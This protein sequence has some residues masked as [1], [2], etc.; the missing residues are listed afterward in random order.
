MRC[1]WQDA[2]DWDGGTHTVFCAREKCKRRFVRTATLAKDIRG[3]NSCR[4]FPIDPQ[5]A[6]PIPA[7]GPG[8]EL[9]KIFTALGVSGKC[10]GG[11]PEWIAKM[12]QGVGW[13]EAHREEILAHLKSAYNE[14]GTLAKLRAAGNLMVQGFP[15]CSLDG[16]LSLAI[17]R[18]KVH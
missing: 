3:D 2:K 4:A 6:D 7:P 17:E 8:T 12:N 18:A 1:D 5:Q 10:G 13:C 14:A 9:S 11:C 16:M 15:A